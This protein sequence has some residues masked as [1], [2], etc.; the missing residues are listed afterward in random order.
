MAKIYQN[1]LS[2]VFFQHYLA[3]NKQYQPYLS[4]EYIQTIEQEPYELHLIEEKVQRQ[5]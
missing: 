3:G 5:E 1:I 2:L 4:S